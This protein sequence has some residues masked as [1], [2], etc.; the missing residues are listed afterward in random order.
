MG[1]LFMDLLERL[2]YWAKILPNKEAIKM[3]K[4]SVTYSE[5]KCKVT[6]Y[7]FQIA[8]AINDS[9]RPIIIYM[10]RGVDFVVT[11]LAILNLG[12]SYIPIEKK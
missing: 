2:E 7:S 9:E 5:L 1:M 10:E 6:G 11:M 12:M 3:G 8:K 4:E